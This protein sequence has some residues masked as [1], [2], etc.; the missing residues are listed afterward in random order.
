MNF[1]LDISLIIILYGIMDILTTYIALHM[2]Y[3]EQNPCGLFL[4]GFGFMALILAKITVLVLIIVVLKICIN[5]NM[6]WYYHFLSKALIIL[7]L[8]ITLNNGILILF[9]ISIFHYL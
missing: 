6:I 8:I 3:S 7:G 2:G 9:D 5:I 1:K 4:L